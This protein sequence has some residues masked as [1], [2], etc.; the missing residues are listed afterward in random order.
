MKKKNKSP[1]LVAL[2]LFLLGIGYIVVSG[3]SENS[4][5]FLNV[6]EA[7]AMPS[8]ELKAAR[9]F[10]TVKN[11]RA[12]FS[13][14]DGMAKASRLFGTVKNSEIYEEGRGVAVRFMLEDQTD[15]QQLLPVVY[16]GSVPDTFKDGAEV[17]V[18]GGYAT[19]D[20]H[21]K[22]KTLMTKCPSKYEK[23]NRG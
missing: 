17:I 23:E 12:A 6:S 8:E 1:Y 9:L 15:K 11:R 20:N 4:V 2:T 5:Y 7:L 16:L 18:E 14:S 21:F 10:G 22:A 13:S 19:T 3:I